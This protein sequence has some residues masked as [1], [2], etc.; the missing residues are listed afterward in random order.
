MLAAESG[1]KPWEALDLTPRELALWLKGRAQAKTDHWRM[2]MWGAWHIAAYSRAKK[3]PKLEP[4]LR[5]MGGA[6]RKR[7]TVEQQVALAE[8]LNAAF[9]GKDLRTLN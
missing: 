6:K 5:R 1:L 9:G 8:M 3:L 2:T 7:Q 4:I